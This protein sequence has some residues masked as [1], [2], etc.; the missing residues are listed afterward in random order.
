MSL[1]IFAEISRLIPQAILNGD[2][3]TRLPNNVNF[4]VP[5]LDAE[6]TLLKLDA[7][8]LSCSTKSSCL[9]SAGGSYVV[10][11][12]GGGEARAN[13]TLRF[14]FGRET[15][16]KDIDFLLAQLKTLVV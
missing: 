1:L 9:G 12:L 3:I 14:T 4:S 7:A 2:E 8:G 16:K 5:G 11:A 6:F 10:R 13:S 15:T